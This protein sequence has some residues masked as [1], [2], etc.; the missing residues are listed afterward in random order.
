MAYDQPL[1][2]GFGAVVEGLEGLSEKWF[3]FRRRG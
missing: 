2:A 1:A 3:R